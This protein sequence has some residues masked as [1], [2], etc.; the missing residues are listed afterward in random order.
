VIG[1]QSR[2]R[3]QMEN[4]PLSSSDL[5]RSGTGVRIEADGDLCYREIDFIVFPPPPNDVEMRW[6]YHL[7]LWSLFRDI[8]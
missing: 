6:S 3:R 4:F 8:G 1:S 2:F 5:M 7:E